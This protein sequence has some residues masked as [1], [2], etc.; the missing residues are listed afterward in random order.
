MYVCLRIYWNFI[1]SLIRTF[2][3]VSITHIEYDIYTAL[4]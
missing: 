1:H 3:N 4:A 2:V